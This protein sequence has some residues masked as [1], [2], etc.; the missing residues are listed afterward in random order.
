MP[1]RMAIAIALL[2][3]V[4][5]ATVALASEPPPAAFA[6]GRVIIKYSPDATADDKAAIRAD[7]GGTL[8]K[9]L[10][11]I[12]A[13][14]LDV[15]NYSVG[16]AVERYM[17]DDHIAYIEP[18]YIVTVFETPDDPMFD[19]LWGLDNT[20]Q[21]G[22]TAGADIDA[23]RAWDVFTG[24][25]DVVVVVI[26]TGTDYTHPDIAA[27][28][29][30]NPGEIP[31]NGIDDDGNGFIDDIHGWDFYND[32]SNPMD[33]HGHGTHCAGTIGAVGNNGIGVVGVNWTV[34]IMACKFLSSGG[35]GS[36]SDAI[37]AI[38]Y[39]TMMG[40][41]VM[42]NSWGGGGYSEALEDAIQAAYDAGIMFVAAAGNSSQNT[43]TYPHY[44][45]SYTTGNVVSVAAT[46]HNDGLASF[47]NYGLVSVDLGA[48]GDD[49]YSTF[50]GNSY[51]TLSGTSMATPHVSGAAALIMGRFPAMNVDQVKA[52]LLNSVDPIPGLAGKCV[53]E[54]RLNVFNCI[55][56][57]DSIPPA[58]I[59]DLAASNPASNTM[60][61]DWTATGDDGLVGTASYYDVRYSTVPIDE[62][63]FFDA[64]RDYGAPDP[65]PSGTAEHMMVTGLDFNTLYYFAVK[66]IDE[67]GNYSDISNLATGTT[68][69]VPDIDVSPTSLS[70]D[71][72]SG[73]ASV[74]TLT[75]FNLGEGTLDFEIAQ[76]TLI[77]GTTVMG[78]YMDV[79]KG[80][81]DPRTGDP[82]I[83]GQGGPDATGYRW[84]D[85]DE[86][87]GPTFAWVDIT[88]VGTQISMSGDDQNAGPYPIGFDFEFYGNT[89][90]S[91]NICT[92]GFISFTSTS[93]AYSNQP[94]PNTGA[95]ENLVAGFWDDLNFSGSNKAYYYNDG[96]RLIVEYYDVPHY[97]TGGNYTFE[98]ILYPDGMILY[99]YLSMGDPTNS[100]TVGIQN[101]A[102]DDGLE[103]V[104]NSDYIHDNLAVKIAKMP[105][106][107]DVAPTSGRVY[108]GSSL[109]VSVAFDATGLLGG[110]YDASIFIAS[111]DPDEDPVTVPVSLHVT[112]APDI[113]VAPTTVDF[114][115]VF[116]GAT[117][118]TTVVVSNPGTD[119]LTISDITSDN[120]DF[121]ASPTSFTL[122]PRQAELVQIYF[123]PS[124]E[125]P[126]AGTLTIESDDPDERFVDVGAQGV[127]LVPPQFDVDPVSLYADL[128]TGESQEDTLTIT[129]NGG[130]DLDF[131]VSVE[132]FMS[133]LVEQG[134]YVEYGKDDIDPMTSGPQTE[135]TGGPDVF[136]YTWIDSDEPGGP[137]F[138]WV[139]LSGGLGTPIP[140]NSDDQNLG[141]YPIGFDFSFYGN[142]FSEFYACTNG[143]VSFTSTETKY[144]NY[145]LPNA[146]TGVPENLLAVWWDDLKF[147]TAGEAYY[148][149]DGTRLIIEYKDV[150][151]IYSGGP[152]TFEIILYPN[153]TIIY[154]Y[155]TM[156]PNLES[157]TIGIQNET[158]DDGLTV[159][160]NAAYMHD[161][162]AIRF[163]AVPEW[164]SVQPASGTV[165]AGE[166]MEMLA[167]FNATDLFGGDYL[168]AI[169]IDSND[170]NV[171]RYDVPAH[172]HVTGAPDIAAVPDNLDFGM[173]YLGLSTVRQ[174]EVV[175]Q[176]TDLLTV[177]DIVTGS[178]EYSVSTTSFTVEP[179]GSQLIDV[180]Y[181]PSAVGD[182]SNILTIYSDDPDEPQLV[183][184]LAGTC[185]EPPVIVVTP[186][187]VTDSLLTGE[188]SNHS[189]RVEN[190]GDSDLDFMIAVALAAD[191]VQGDFLDVP[192]GEED[193]R[194]GGP[195]LE[196]TGGPDNFGYSWVDSDEP[197][198]PIFD[199]VDITTVGTLIELDGDDNSYGP[200]PIGFDFPFYGNAFSGFYICTN[201]FISF[202]CDDDYYSNQ[203][204]PND[205]YRV[206]ENMIAP[207]WDDLRIYSG[208]Y[209]TYYYYDGTR[210]IIEFFEV[211]RLSSSYPG[212]FTFEVILYPNGKIVCQ[213]LTM[214][215]EIEDATIGIQN[216]LKDDGLTV[217]FNDAYMH[218]NLAVQF[219]YAPDWLSVNPTE[220]TVPPGG[221]QD[222]N[223]RF[224]A[225]ELFGGWYYGSLDILSNDP[226]NG[227]V[228]VDASL[229]V[230][231]APDIAVDPTAL[232]FGWLYISLAETLTV[233]VR[234]EG[235]DLLQVT[236]LA[237]DH[238]EF[239]T[240]LTP[241]DLNPMESRALEV[242]YTPVTEGMV[243]GTLTL[244]S[245]DA[246]EPE[247]AVPLT[248]EGVVP[249]EIDVEPDTLRAAAMQG[250]VVTRNLR[251][252]NDGGS[253]LNYTV[254]HMQIDAVQVHDYLE[255]PKY[256]E[257]PRPGIPA[258]DGMGGPDAFGYTWIDSDEPGGPVYDW[259]D[260][261]AVGTPIFG[262][263]SDDGN[264]G[265][266]DIGFS[267]PF[268]DGVFDQ[269][270]VC[271]NGW[272]SFTSTSTQYSNQPLPNSGAPENLL[273]VW[274]DDMVVD[275][276]DD[277]EIYY[278]NDGSRLIVQYEI[279]RIAQSSP[280]YYS[281]QII[282]YPD[283][284]ILYQYR[285]FG[286]TINSATI[287]IQNG[288]RDDG[289]TV[290]FNADYAHPEMAILFSSGPDWLS[291]YPEA[292]SIP[293]GSY[294][295]LT[296]TFDATEL[297]DGLY[298][299]LVTILS[300]DLDEPVVNVPAFLTVDWTE[301][302]FMDIDPNTLN[303]GSNGKWIECKVG[304]PM[305]FDPALVIGDN[306]FLVAGDDT[307][308]PAE[309]FNVEECDDTCD[310]YFAHFKWNR[311]A[312]QSMLG[313]GQN[314][315]IM[316]ACEVQDINWIVGY[317]Y[318]TVIN[319]KM[320]HPNGGEEFDQGENLI[321]M[322]EPPT[323]DT[324]DSYTV[325]FSE[326]DGVTWTE[327][328]SGITTQSVIVDVPNIE[329]EQALI[330]VFALKN[331]TP[332][333]YDTSDEVFTIK[334][335]T[336]AGVEDVLPT[337]FALQQNW[338]N[339]FMGTTMLHFDIPKD[340]DVKLEVFD[341]QGRLVK[342]LVDQPLPAG[343]YDIGWD[344]RDH[345]GHRVASGV[346]FYRIQ[347]GQWNETK[348]M[349]IVR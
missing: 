284:K 301:A 219:S 315:E 118:S 127:G 44:P 197:G 201:G 15:Q 224:N 113:A 37:D 266:F 321:V 164:L 237:L 30:T 220:G 20:G 152:Y 244:Y 204:L 117:V 79:P 58:A 77:L 93:T 214:T 210:C 38:T 324:P 40:V 172:L 293:A 259:V 154:Q 205:Y 235:T 190:T 98:I 133:G 348:R 107:V 144:S 316:V 62:G 320:N 221:F 234:N 122:A 2:L 242:V 111:N 180:S 233:D 119:N 178:T 207:W 70:E 300:N 27:N 307:L 64:A 128:M 336:G 26:D 302:T 25:E 51:G 173:V 75:I 65:G 289:L 145:E 169:H 47:S 56:E 121:W 288:A 334:P 129:N 106:W 94:I 240:D 162:L 168:G 88:G 176:G 177:T 105:Q 323:L 183:V 200:V 252:M 165:P 277:G 305:E 243:S 342:A 96:T 21:T 308:T 229:H 81:V 268:Y 68:L 217:V 123:L 7:L 191:V 59:D 188:V 230:T 326:D 271:S 170:P 13:E 138:D 328:A 335:A 115:G 159:V 132:L 161:N 216:E 322:W 82:V 63:N 257:D 267:F 103:V 92:N 135:G 139:E 279:R 347:A 102:R 100:A 67:Y 163:A 80:A 345:Q 298:E 116:I 157:A 109:D 245:N 291:V 137:T 28:A 246:D 286:T 281:F 14:V 232:D 239:T 262:A 225:A 156:T 76:P 296:V 236:S 125:G 226:Y 50:P 270:R 31:G 6:P 290:V 280:P 167:R 87:G 311:E 250:M 227:L 254:G 155:L 146:G 97:S 228:S 187:A 278:Y 150:P 72:I 53:S 43:D 317:D 318:I 18:D 29:W 263:Y 143:W 249:P 256:E 319:P 285:Q 248:G 192:K 57:P 3:T 275:P 269:F 99:Q 261:S 325:L 179:L 337:V 223:V 83:D 313:E 1:K 39:A 343:R 331:D 89:Y 189:V 340:V 344:G 171:P 124:L 54:G 282:L 199:W 292:G 32:D 101:A 23:L 140:L 16:G 141:P 149:Y 330:R 49:I 258:V 241:F 196:S 327:M 60:D 251:I 231:G 151:R 130:S 175:N 45:S 182:R 272:L 339:P 333:G 8:I 181:H 42:S 297:E 238:P 208:D 131:T 349:V 332:I 346:Y 198:G 73:G 341:V 283:G 160:Y 166:T 61:L 147:T 312:V 114:G 247:V 274:W 186:T 74:Q 310:G 22:G 71:L 34:K 158:R 85:S 295:D 126:I 287:G 112:G 19:Q 253:D 215:G 4:A 338:P 33:D 218:D 303:L 213:Y 203:P 255:V 142:T 153:G 78:D 90:D 108:G 66:A 314:V 276:S 136:G 69:G 52:L 35:S 202:T 211:S 10:D 209:R 304:I 309:R 294:Q 48:P 11:L 329:T 264:R 17:V 206:C 265:P 36:T 84:I 46:D 195:Q 260:V 134:V 212:T 185:L 174:F 95:P 86:P 299:G 273:A 193:P 120:G 222:L 104:F 55:A 148:Y 5:F 306:A 9:T 184:P 41:D 91:F 110:D 24:S 12:D 194:S